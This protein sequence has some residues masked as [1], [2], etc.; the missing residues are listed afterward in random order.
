MCAKC[1]R[2]R[3][4]SREP[5]PYR[6]AL[7]S[8]HLGENTCNKPFSE[9]DFPGQA[10]AYQFS[11]WGLNWSQCSRFLTPT[12]TSHLA[13]KTSHTIAFFIKLT[14][15]CCG[16]PTSRGTNMISGS[17]L[18]A[19]LFATSLAQ[20]SCCSAVTRLSLV[21]WPFLPAMLRSAWIFPIGFP[22]NELAFRTQS[23]PAGTPLMTPRTPP[24]PPPSTPS[25]ALAFA[26]MTPPELLEHLLSRSW[27]NHQTELG[28]AWTEVAG[29][30]QSDLSYGLSKGI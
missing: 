29:Q 15:F 19:I 30:S 1:G 10:P 20:I 26:P 12:Q 24:G 18:F 6:E 3:T 23:S 21:P 25:D 7:P 2:S 16:A 5:A 17:F 8:S 22:V 9:K 28:T 14:S 4:S 11:I 27:T 13:W